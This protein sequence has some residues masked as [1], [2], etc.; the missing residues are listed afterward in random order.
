MTSGVRRRAAACALLCALAVPPAAAAAP[1]EAPAPLVFDIERNGATIGRHSV[2]FTTEE[3]ADGPRLHVDIAIRILVTFASIPVFRYEHDSHE[4]WANDMLVGL[5]TWTN[6][7]GEGFR[8]RAWRD[9]DRLA[10]DGLA[11]RLSLP[12]STA[13]TSYWHPRFRV[14][15][16]ALDS[17]RGTLKQ[18][19]VA[20][21]PDE[22]IE[23]DGRPVPA[24]H[25]RTSGELDLDLWYLPNGE[26][27]KL[28]FMA[29]GALISYVRRDPTAAAR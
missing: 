15:R 5:D 11:G 10:V 13:P 9:G 1:H 20:A 6:D 21:L 8:A 29:K 14:A 3:T 27:A 12:A 24:L 2:R 4:I 28:A 17:Q 19:A 16:E 7:D 25:Y 22:T 23:V 26:W 18:L